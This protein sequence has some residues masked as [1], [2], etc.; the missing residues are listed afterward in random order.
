MPTSGKKQKSE[1][2]RADWQFILLHWLLSGLLVVG[3]AASGLLGDIS[4]LKMFA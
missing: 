3:L 4:F 2:H 1:F